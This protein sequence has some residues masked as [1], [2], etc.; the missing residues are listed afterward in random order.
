MKNIKKIIFILL[1][2]VISISL[3]SCKEKNNDYKLPI[4]EQDSPEELV[5]NFSIAWSHFMNFSI[6][7]KIFSDFYNKTN[8]HNFDSIL[9]IRGEIKKDAKEIKNLEG[10]HVKSMSKKE[11]QKKFLDMNKSDIY[12]KPSPDTNSTIFMS[13]EMENENHQ[14][15]YYLYEIKTYPLVKEPDVK[16]I[17]GYI[18]T[19]IK[20]D[21]KYYISDTQIFGD[22]FW[23]NKNRS[24]DDILKWFSIYEYKNNKIK[25]KK[26]K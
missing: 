5:K 26:I 11:F 21:N 2:I 16:H 3:I 8:I 4:I 12:Y 20:K 14:K 1:T 19:L 23:K 10:I 9:F 25:Y 18:Y 13:D 7:P 17:I 22:T 24:L 15:M 6:N